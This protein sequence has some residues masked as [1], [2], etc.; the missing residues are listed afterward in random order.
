[1]LLGVFQESIMIAHEYP[2]LSLSEV[3]FPPFKNL[4]D[5]ATKLC[6]IKVHTHGDVN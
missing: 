4:E 3:I 1:M 5:T 6:V 2:S